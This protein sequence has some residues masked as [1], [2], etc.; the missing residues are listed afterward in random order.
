MV[1]AEKI[2]VNV[3]LADLAHIRQ[4]GEQAAMALGSDPDAVGEAIVAINEA[5]ANIIRHGY[6]G[7][8]GRIEIAVQRDGL[9]LVIKIWDNA[10]LFNPLSVPEPNT[11]LPLEQRPFGGMGV[12][13]MR[14]FSDELSYQITPEGRNEV[15]LRKQ[16]AFAGSHLG[17]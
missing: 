4:Y 14:H 17:G 13:M 6:Q 11:S 9:D 16:N 1:G 10:P 8:P 15:T 5:V 12:Y 3:S 2:F 7:R